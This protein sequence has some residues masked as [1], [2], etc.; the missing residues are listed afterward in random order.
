MAERRE[1]V[2]NPVLH[3][4]TSPTSTKPPGGGK[5]IKR[6]RDWARYER[7]RQALLERLAAL[8][9][10]PATALASHGGRYLIWAGMHGDSIASSHTPDD[11]FSSNIGTIMKSAWRDGYVIEAT[12]QALVRLAQRVSNAATNPLKCDIYSVERLELFATVLVESNVIDTAWNAASKDDDG[13]RRFNVR[14]ADYGPDEAR[15]SVVAK[16]VA[17]A[18]DNRIRLGN[19]S[20]PRP[21]GDGTEAAPRAGWLAPAAVQG[22]VH[23]RRRLPIG[24]REKESLQELVLSGSVVRWEAIA[25]LRPTQPGVGAEPPLDLPDMSGDPI[26]GVID[27]GY[28]SNR[29]ADAIAWRQIPALVPTVE[30]ARLHGNRVASVVVDAHLWSNQLLLPQLHCRLG[31]VQAVPRDGSSLTLL[32]EETLSHLETAFKA[33]PDTHVWNLSANVERD[34][35]VYEVSEL[36]HGLAEIARRHEKLLVVSAGNRQDGSSRVAPPADCEA[37]LVVAGRESTAEGSVAGACAVSRTG[38]GP[39]GMVKPETSW[40]SSLRVLGGGVASGTSFATPLVSRL[41][42][43]TWQ[44][45]SKPSPDMVKALLLN[46][47][48]LK[49][50]S[51][52]MG[53]GSP[54]RPEL[55]WNCASNSA[56]VAWQA[57]LKAYQSYYWDGLRVPPSLLVNGKFKGRAKL[58]AILSPYTDI[59]GHNYFQTRLSAGLYFQAGEIGDEENK[60]LAGCINPKKLETAARRDD[61]KWDPVRVYERDCRGRGAGITIPG[62]QPELRVGARL[63]WRDTYKYS[64][65]FMRQTPCRVTF[66]VTLESRDS[67]ADTYNEFRRIMAEEVVSAV[68]EQDVEIDDLDI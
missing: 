12:D 56:V 27:G 40:F 37:A 22:A 38:L 19:P 14:I 4:L 17:L 39:E 18:G 43:H 10:E 59:E 23:P 58:V 20:S 30:A 63:Y 68:V 9:K 24:F 44:N 36:G 55:P 66:V 50:Y 52:E 51:P 41:A 3:L 48:D 6:V 45:L 65:E 8:P 42:A 61:N 5:D 67:E 29:Y 26:V 32:N 15:S 62:D 13:L 47:S 2:Q 54:I 1:I 31:I 49:K 16:L 34:C 57:D 33:H 7:H 28:H 60:K 64:D 35:D 46:A 11:L 25:A 53:F 21:T